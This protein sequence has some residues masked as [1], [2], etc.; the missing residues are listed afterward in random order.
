MHGEAHAIRDLRKLLLHILLMAL[1]F[2]LIF[3]TVVVVDPYDMFRVS[4]AVPDSLK[5]KNLYHDGRTMAFS[6]LMWE[7]NAFKRD[8]CPNVLIGDS[9]LSYFP[10]DHLDSVAGQRYFNFGV[11][12]GNYNSMFDTFWY[13]DSLCE[14]KN[15]YLQV[16]FRGMSAASDYDLFH[17]PELV[18]GEPLMYLTNRRVLEATVLNVASAVAPGRVK[19]DELPPDQWQRVLAMERVSDSLFTYDP[20]V[21]EGLRRVAARCR[22]KAIHLVLVDFPTHADVH[23]LAAQAGLALLHERYRADMRAIAPYIDLDNGNDLSAERSNFRD[24]LHLTQDAQ[25]RLV[26]A[27]WGGRAAE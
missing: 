20:R 2:A 4:S 23:A 1:P 18:S 11:P 25:R 3:T 6:N 24:P 14:L 21:L 22:E 7:M 26:D 13:A 10:M 19:Y 8:P 12:G 16:S 9:R 5:E 27:I 17:E 15:V